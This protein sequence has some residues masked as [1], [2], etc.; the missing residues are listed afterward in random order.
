MDDGIVLMTIL[1]QKLIDEIQL[2]GFSPRTQETYVSSVTGLAR[3]YRRAPDQINDDELKAYL[4]YLLLPESL[5]NG[6]ANQKVRP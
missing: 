2:R 6:R 4:L 5:A 3:F 1:R